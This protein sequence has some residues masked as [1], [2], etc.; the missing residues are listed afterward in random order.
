MT[1]DAEV[2]AAINA[3]RRAAEA[4]DGTVA[5]TPTEAAEAQA[6]AL[7]YLQNPDFTSALLGLSGGRVNLNDD[8]RLTGAEVV[9]WASTFNTNPRSDITLENVQNDTQAHVDAA[10]EL[11]SKI[12]GCS[13]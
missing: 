10:R 3:I 13:R 11:K 9:A 12:C 5:D 7:R 2:I 4:P 1:T 6:L 8:T